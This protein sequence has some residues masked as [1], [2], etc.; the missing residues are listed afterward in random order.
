MPGQMS[1]HSAVADIRPI[2]TS[3][4]RPDVTGWLTAAAIFWFEAWGAMGLVVIGLAPLLGFM[5]GTYPPTSWSDGSAL[6]LLIA[7]VVVAAF[8]AIAWAVW[9]RQSR[10]WPLL[11][12]GLGIVGILMIVAT[13]VVHPA[14][15]LASALWLGWPSIVLV[16]VGVARL[17]L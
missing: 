6:G 8:G 11:V 10:R 1:Q 17:R 5:H 3:G 13:A 2:R 14:A 7:L 16:R 9:P 4:S 15:L 12:C